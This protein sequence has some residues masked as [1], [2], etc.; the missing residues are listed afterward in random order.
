M[1]A[2]FLS[3]HLREKMLILGLVVFAIAFWLPSLIG[4][5]NTLLTEKHLDETKLADQQVWLDRRAE[6]D[7]EEAA[8]VNKLKPE[9]SF[10]KLK[11]NSEI[12]KMTEAANVTNRTIGAPTTKTASS[13]QL[14]ISSI[15]VTLS[16][17][18]MPTLVSF[19]RE[20]AK[21]APYITIT[22]CNIV[23]RV[24]RGGRGGGL[25]GLNGAAGGALN[26]RNGVAAVVQNAG[27]GVT[28]TGGPVAGGGR[29]GGAF[30]AADPN[31]DPN[32]P[33]QGGRRGG[34]NAQPV[35]PGNMNVTFDLTA[36]EIIRPGAPAA[37]K[38]AVAPVVPAATAVK[39]T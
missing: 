26:F 18:D 17:V 30:A 15:K 32:A 29:R 10:D 9:L 24:A 19:Y 11:L 36:V 7:D 33:V 13:R 4:R 37:T 3:R 12:V 39:S 6:Y 22:D 31:A 34:A 2:Y 20:L 1:K 27:N 14:A 21:R 5:T 23:V 8:A 38:P 35:L 28:D 25:G 16:N